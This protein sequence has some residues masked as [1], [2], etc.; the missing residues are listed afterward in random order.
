MRWQPHAAVLVAMAV[1]YG[2]AKA[3]GASDVVAFLIFFVLVAS[4]LML[5]RPWWS[6]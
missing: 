6:R 4:A 3:V 1:G 2:I 5:T